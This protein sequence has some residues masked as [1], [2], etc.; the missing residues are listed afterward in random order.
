MRLMRFVGFLTAA[1]AASVTLPGC[2]PAPAV[3]VGC[4]LYA[5]ELAV[6]E[7]MANPLNDDTGREWFEIY[8]TTTKEQVLD[9]LII[10][11]LT[12]KD[13]GSVDFVDHTLRGAG[14]LAAKGYFVLGDGA[15]GVA[16][17]NYSYGA[18]GESFGGLNGTQGGIRL[19]CQGRPIDEVW[20]GTDTGAPVPE[21]GHSL[22]FDGGLAPDAFLNDR[23]DW[24]CAAN[25]D[26]YD[27]VNFGTPGQPN[28]FC[29]FATCRRR[30]G[31]S[32]SSFRCR[33]FTC[34]RRSISRGA[35]VVAPP[36]ARPCSC[37]RLRASYCIR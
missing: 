37:T 35:P 25:G 26:R 14:K 30:P 12:S 11:R 33:S 10:K 5:G 13:A 18:A 17:I 7:I 23:G 6:S 19:E 16:P 3:G 2:G 4:D 8:N 27:G 21:E 29:G 31:G 24:W 32:R 36:S 9:R 28:D 20:Y 22:A 1:A 34:R 15:V